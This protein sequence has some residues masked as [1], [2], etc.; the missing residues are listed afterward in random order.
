[1]LLR[2]YLLTY[3]LRQVRGMAELFKNSSFNVHPAMLE[4]WLELKLDAAPNSEEGPHVRHS[5]SLAH[6]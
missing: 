6:P 1:M 4:A 5:L 3:L 2:P